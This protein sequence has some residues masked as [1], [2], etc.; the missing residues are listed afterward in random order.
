[1]GWLS[2]TNTQSSEKTH[3]KSD[4]KSTPRSIEILSERTGPLGSGAT[5][6]RTPEEAL[7]DSRVCLTR[8]DSKGVD[9]MGQ[10]SKPIQPPISPVSDNVSL[11]LASPALPSLPASDGQY[12]SQELE[13]PFDFENDESLACPPAPHEAEASPRSSLKTPR[14]STEDLSQI[15]PL[16]INVT[17]SCPP[18]PEFRPILVSELPS[19]PLDFSK[20]LI[21]LETCTTTYRT[22]VET[23]TS[24]PSHLS[25]YITLLFPRQRSNSTTSSIYSTNSGDL[26]VYRNHL[27]SQGLLSRTPANL[28]IFLDRPSAPYAHILSYLRSLDPEES[29][30]L[31]TLPRAI[32][33]QPSY[34]QSR[35]EAL[36]ELRDEA[37]YL[38]LDGLYKLCVDEIR[39]RQPSLTPRLH[40]RN[41]SRTL[42]S[43]TYPGR[44]SV[45]SQQASVHSF[46]LENTEVKSVLRSKRQ[47]VSNADSTSST[48]GHATTMRT[49]SPPTPLS[50]RDARSSTTSSRSRSRTRAVQSPPAGWI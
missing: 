22:T 15:P 49:R 35:L 23:L 10:R 48:E 44:I 28:H 40:S 2:R 27:A 17:P 47:D 30:L 43:S 31:D 11:P 38:N 36:L 8:Y 7:Q 4:S 26:S 41:Q 12:D 16:P 24:R 1:M 3:R 19:S 14:S 46:P 50:W 9:E 39:Q 5:I 32:Q 25:A 45:Q 18:Q 6:V 13:D 42:Q 37:A 20:V 34:T 21:T 33:L 29:G